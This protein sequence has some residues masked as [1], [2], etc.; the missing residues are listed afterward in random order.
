MI[1]VSEQRFDDMVADALDKLPDDFA[2]RLRNVVILVRDHNDEDPSILGLYEGVALP[3]RTFDHTGYLPDAIFIY[4][5][6]LEAVCHT[7]EQ[8]AQQIEVTVFHEVGHYF[9]ID[10]GKLHELGWG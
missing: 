2:R 1:A 4:K 3:D 6:A 9:G 8:L 7:E 5:K 10:E